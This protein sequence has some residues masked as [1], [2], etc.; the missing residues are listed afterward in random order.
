MPYHYATVEP[1]RDTAGETREGGR[2]QRM[3]N[4]ACAGCLMSVDQRRLVFRSTRVRVVGTLI[5]RLAVAF[6]D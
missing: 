2:T 6:D 3:A 4:T 5:G 1:W